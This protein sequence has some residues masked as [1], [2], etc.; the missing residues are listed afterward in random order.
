MNND[1][2]WG[3]L[4]LAVLFTLAI[5]LCIELS[6]IE[7]FCIGLSYGILSQLKF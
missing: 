6:T 3:S 1:F 7:A 4:I 2:Y 5:A